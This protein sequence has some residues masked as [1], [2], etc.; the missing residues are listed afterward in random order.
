MCL[1]LFH[2]FIPETRVLCTNEIRINGYSGKYAN[3]SCPHSWA[4]NNKKYFCRDPCDDTDILVSSDRSP[5][6]RF[7]LEDFGNGVFTVT[8]TDL[9][10]SDSGIY[11]CG[12]S[13]VGKDTYHKVNLRVSKA[14]TPTS[15]ILDT[16][17]PFSTPQPGTPFATSSRTSRS[18]TPDDI[19]TSSSMTVAVN[20]SLYAVGG[21]VAVIILLCVLVAVHQYRKRI[22]RNADH[23]PRTSIKHNDYTVYRG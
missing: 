15:T 4:S 7:R 18:T 8:I 20:I 5:N 6:G 11:W 19:T 10:E 9:Q 13:R 12:V 1:T 14:I 2:Y 17:H 22:N 16:T 23:V 21:L 3:F